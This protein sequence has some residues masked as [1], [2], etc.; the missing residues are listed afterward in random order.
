MCPKDSKFT[1]ICK[2]AE[3]TM[4]QD[5]TTNLMKVDGYS[6]RN[7][8]FLMTSTEV[9]VE[10]QNVY[11]RSTD[12]YYYTFSYENCKDLTSKA[13]IFKIGPTGSNQISTSTKNTIE[14]NFGASSN[15]VIF[16]KVQCN[17]T[18]NK[19]RWFCECC[20]GNDCKLITVYNLKYAV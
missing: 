4:C 19:K 10:R 12:G 1:E 7:A 14:M 2:I 3:P 11:V 5:I 13:C 17:I 18:M 20:S 8:A 6:R 16:E 9:L 15:L